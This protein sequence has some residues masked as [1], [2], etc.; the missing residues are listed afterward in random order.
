MQPMKPKAGQAY[1]LH[2]FNRLMGVGW[3][4]ADPSF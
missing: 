4:P 2:R 3:P 1:Q